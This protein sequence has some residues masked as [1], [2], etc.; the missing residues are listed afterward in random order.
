M[1]RT[2]LTAPTSP[3]KQLATKAKWKSNLP[4]GGVKDA[5]VHSSLDIEREMYIYK[6]DYL[7]DVFPHEDDEFLH[8]LQE[9]LDL[10][11]Q[12]NKDQEVSSDL[13]KENYHYLEAS[14]ESDYEDTTP[15]PSSH[16]WLFGKKKTIF[17]PPPPTKPSHA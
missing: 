12:L 4:Q 15:P 7:H 14:S 6:N 1:V 13:Y 11:N 2:K 10:E 3:P 9:G 5:S 16:L 17:F 8:H